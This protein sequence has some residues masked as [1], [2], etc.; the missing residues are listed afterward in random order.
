MYSTLKRFLSAITAIAVAFTVTAVPVS[1]AALSNDSVSAAAGTIT[2]VYVNPLYADVITESDLLS[3][4]QAAG[5]SLLEDDVYCTTTAEAG[6]IL[7]SAMK[8]R[9]ETV[10][11]KYRA[12]V[13]NFPNDDAVRNVLTEICSQALVHTGRPDEGDYIMWQY[14]G[15][16]GSISGFRQDGIY[17]MTATYTHL[18]FASLCQPF[19]SR[20]V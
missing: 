5:T 6:E 2:E 16:K 12:P 4:S 1:A 19:T 10:T 3:P 15:W 13:D 14:A 8:E 9:T 7:R 17:Y 11:V 20:R 18:I